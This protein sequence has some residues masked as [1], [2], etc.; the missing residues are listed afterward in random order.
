M[1]AIGSFKIKDAH[2]GM[3]SPLPPHKLKSEATWGTEV[4]MRRIEFH[5]FKAKTRYGLKQSTF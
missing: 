3:M 2:I 1:S 4:I 5:N